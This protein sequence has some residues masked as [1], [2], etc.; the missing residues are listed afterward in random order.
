MMD[1]RLAAGEAAAAPLL[2]ASGNHTQMGW[3]VAHIE[4]AAAIRARAEWSSKN[5]TYPS[6]RL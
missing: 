4:T 5:T 6:S 3:V 1:P 2:L